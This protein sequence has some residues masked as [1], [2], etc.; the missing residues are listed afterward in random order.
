MVGMLSSA[1]WVVLSRILTCALDLTHST[2]APAKQEIRQKFHQSY[3]HIGGQRC[4]QAALCYMHFPP[5]QTGTVLS[6]I[7]SLFA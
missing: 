3:C 7:V 1:L 2:L 5:G 6:V 4:L